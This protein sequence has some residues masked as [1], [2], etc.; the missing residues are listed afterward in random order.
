MKRYSL[1]HLADDSLLVALRALA[2][3][4]RLTTAELL[5][6]L[7]EV[8]ARRLYAPLACASMRAYCVRELRFSEDEAFKRIQAARAGREFPTVFEMLAAGSLSLT[9]AVK[10]AP[11]LTQANADE[12]L[13]AAAG[14]TKHEVETLLAEH[15]PRPDVP[16][17]VTPLDAA[18]S[19]NELVPE[20]VERTHRDETPAPVDRSLA[21]RT[22]PLAPERFALQVT[23]SGD[24]QRKLERA[25]EL[26]SHAI[27]DKNVAQ[28]LDR[29]LDALIAQLEKRR[30]GATTRPGRRTS[31]GK[32]RYVPA[33][34][35]RAVWA[36]DGSRCT[37]VGTNGQR[38]DSRTR[39]ELDHVLPIAQGG[40]STVGNLRLRCRAHNQ[41]EAERAFGERFVQTKRERAAEERRRTHAREQD[42]DA[43][44][45]PWLRHLGVPLERA[46]RAA[47]QTEALGDAPLE[48]R[49][50]A[51]LRTLAP[52]RPALPQRPGPG[53][54]APA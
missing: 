11:H 36:R 46:R 41:Y 48:T 26:L 51:A 2:A 28:V 43:S 52:A 54:A 32:S 1:S 45:I 53:P 9:A 39:L 15:F 27:P 29:A 50:H 6:H 18:D 19:G 12:L 40:A 16:A 3:R 17:C 38:C 34:V 10:L 42:A 23:I 13:R 7:A 44:V 4:E 14:R 47:E 49:L 30:T 33:E 25:R 20:P 24:T 37:F 21:S 31:D 35:K 5:A 8:D 22:T